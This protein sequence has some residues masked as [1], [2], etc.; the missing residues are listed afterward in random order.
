MDDVDKILSD[1]NKERELSVKIES[2]KIEVMSKAINAIYPTGSR[3]LHHLPKRKVFAEKGTAK[4]VG[5]LKE[6][7]CLFD[8]DDPLTNDTVVGL[9]CD[10]DVSVFEDCQDE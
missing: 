5:E 4:T 6:L 7:L 9:W 8:D 2:A 1:Y 3:V 10:G